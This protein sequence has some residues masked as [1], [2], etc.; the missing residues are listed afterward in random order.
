MTTRD[1]QHLDLANPIASTFL[2]AWHWTDSTIPLMQS[3]YRLLTKL[4]EAEH[5]FT[6]KYYAI[7]A[8]PNLS[9]TGKK[10]SREDAFN[11]TLA[12]VYR[13][14]QTEGQS[15]KNMI[16]TL[17]VNSLPR[18]D[19]ADFGAALA[20][21]DIR[22]I[23]LGM[24]AMAKIAAIKAYPSAALA[25]AL[26]EFPPELIGLTQQDV[27]TLTD[28]FGESAY[29]ENAKK[30]EELTNGLEAVKILMS[31]AIAVAAA[32]LDLDKM[33]VEQLIWGGKLP[34]SKRL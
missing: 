5:R 22:R 21:S 25:A 23:F 2:M 33:Q 17:K 3:A 16:A 28:A 24:D 8:N 6:D 27:Q 12:P 13:D 14:L 10:A 11:A 15:M 7:V 32:N 29:P 19:P 20:R 18:P 1:M 26:L 9:A 34:D 4:A 31:M 30:I